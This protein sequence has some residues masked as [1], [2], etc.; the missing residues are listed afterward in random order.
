MCCSCLFALCCVLGS[1]TCKKTGPP[2]Q[3]PT[4][5]AKKVHLSYSTAYSSLSSQKP[6]YTSFKGREMYLIVHCGANLKSS[7]THCSGT[8]ASAGTVL[9]ITVFHENMAQRLL[10]KQCA[11]Y[12]SLLHTY[13]QGRG[14]SLMQVEDVGCNT[15]NRGINSSG[16]PVTR[17]CR[18]WIDPRRA[19]AKGG[20]QQSF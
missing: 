9:L 3:H 10:G 15:G 16:L 18:G 17:T 20:F 5:F 8:T 6:L 12:N 4:G 11:N 7:S 13:P 19:V 2:G 14:R 1:T